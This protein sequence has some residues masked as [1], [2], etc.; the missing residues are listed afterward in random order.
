MFCLALANVEKSYIRLAL[1]RYKVT[2]LMD[3]NKVE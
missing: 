3:E 2:L 1:I